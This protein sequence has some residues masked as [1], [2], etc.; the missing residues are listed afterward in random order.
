MQTWIEAIIEWVNCLGVHPSPVKDVRDLENKSIYLKIIGQ[1]AG[2]TSESPTQISEFLSK[3]YPEFLPQHSSNDII[4]KDVY[5]ASL[6]LLTSSQKISFHRPM[7]NLR[8]DTQILIKRFLEVLL[9]Y[10]K[11]ITQG[12]LTSTI[13]ELID[14]TPRTPPITPKDR[15]LRNFF[16]SPAAQSAHRHRILNEKTR[17]LRLLKAELETERYEKMDLQ[18]DIRIR[19][20]KIQTLQKKL[21]E[22]DLELKA[23]KADKCRPHTPQTGRKNKALEDMEHMLKKEI[24]HLESFNSHLQD[25]LDSAESDKEELMRKLTSKERLSQVLKEK[26]ETY[27]R[28]LE[29]LSIQLDQKSSELLQLRLQNEELRSHIKDM[30]RCS[31]DADQSF[32]VDSVSISR[33]PIPGLNTSEALSSIVD[34]QLQEAKEESSKLKAELT[35][36]HLR[37]DEAHQSCNELNRVNRELAI[38]TDELIIVKEKLQQTNEELLIME[39][40]IRTLEEEKM[41]F[42]REVENLQQVL[43][44]KEIILKETT[45]NCK[46]L[47]TKIEE[48][49]EIINETTE[50]IRI[51]NLSLTSHQEDMSRI[52]S[53]KNVLQNDFDNSKHKINELETFL[54]AE[55]SKSSNIVKQA[56]ENEQILEEKIIEIKLEKEKLEKNVE[57]MTVALDESAENLHDKQ[58]KI[59]SL[60]SL[61]D[62]LQNHQSIQEITL[63]NLQMKLCELNELRD[64][65]QS[66]VDEERRNCLRV[67]LEQESLQ[68]DLMAC[69]KEKMKLIDQSTGLKADLEEMTRRAEELDKQRKINEE[70]Y[71]KTSEKIQLLQTDNERLNSDIFSATAEMS[72]LKELQENLENQLTQE[73]ENSMKLITEKA[74]IE[75]ELSNKALMNCDLSERVGELDVQLSKTLQE[76]Q[77]LENVHGDL[78]GNYQRSVE[79][80]QRLEA[81]VF[82]T[83]DDIRRYSQQM[84]EMKS[85]I[86]RLEGQLE[87][88][89]C[90]VKS[91]LHD[92][93]ELESELSSSEG[94]KREVMEK[95]V[96][97]EVNLKNS[98]RKIE[99]IQ[100]ESEKLK[101]LVGIK[102]GEIECQLD[103]I[104]VLKGDLEA[105]MTGRSASEMRLKESERRY[106]EAVDRINSMASQIEQLNSELTRGVLEREALQDDRNRIAEEMSSR[107]SGL[108]KVQDALEIELKTSRNDNEA[109]SNDKS[110]LTQELSI[111]KEEKGR[112]KDDLKSNDLILREHREKIT[113]LEIY[114]GE[115][116]Q[117]R[118]E[119][120]EI[121]NS[122]TSDVKNLTSVLEQ[123]ILERDEVQNNLTGLKK[124]VTMLE[125]Q[126]RSEL[127]KNG[128]ISGEKSFLTSE[129]NILQEEN[130]HL[131]EK[132][133]VNGEKLTILN[134]EIEELKNY[135]EQLH[136]KYEKSTKKIISM[137]SEMNNFIIKLDETSI[138]RDLLQENLTILQKNIE[139][140]N[141]QLVTGREV[142]EILTTEKSDISVKLSS[143][144]KDKVDLVEKLACRESELMELQ[145]QNKNLEV[146]SKALQ[147]NLTEGIEKIN[148]LNSQ[149][150]NLNL[151]LQKMIPDLTNR[152]R[153]LSDQLEKEKDMIQVLIKEKSALTRELSK[154]KEENNNLSLNLDS[155]KSQL[156]NSNE[157]NEKL[158]RLSADLQEK[159]EESKDK[160]SSMTSEIGKLSFK[161][162]KTI[163]ECDLM[164]NHLK[165]Q[166]ETE[167]D[168][169][170]SEK[171]SLVAQLS[172]LKKENDDLVKNLNSKLE[173]L[174]NN[175]H[176]LE[177]KER[178]SF[179]KN[180]SLHS[181]IDN[182]TLQLQAAILE[183]NAC[184]LSLNDCRNEL[185]DSE[186][187]LEVERIRNQ[188]LSTEKCFLKTENEN[189]LGDVMSAKEKLLESKKKIE[190]LQCI[191]ETLQQSITESSGKITSQRSEIDTLT[192]HLTET[193]SAHNAARDNLAD[194]VK[195]L[196]MTETE[197]KKGKEEH[198]E[199]TATINRLE[200]LVRSLEGRLLNLKTTH[201]KLKINHKL[202]EEAFEVLKLKLEVSIR[203]KIESDLKLKE[204]ILS[205]Q[206]IRTSQDGVMEAQS[207]A[208]AQKN[209]ELE[210]LEQQ[211]LKCKQTLEEKINLHNVRNTELTKEL[212]EL[213]QSQECSSREMQRL[214]DYLK[215]ERN[216]LTCLKEELRQCKDEKS[217][218]LEI[219]K[220]LTSKLSTLNSIITSDGTIVLQ[221]DEIGDI[222]H[223]FEYPDLQELLETLKP[224]VNSMKSSAETILTLNVENKKL[225]GNLEEEKLKSAFLVKEKEKN[226]KLIDAISQL[227]SSQK[228]QQEAVLSIISRKQCFHGLVDEV[229][230]SRD[231]VEMTLSSLCSSWR[232]IS[233]EKQCLLS[234]SS[235]ACDE[236]KHLNAKRLEIEGMMGKI[237]ERHNASFQPLMRGFYRVLLWCQHQ[238]ANISLK[239][240]LQ[241]I[242]MNLSHES[243]KIEDPDDIE[244]DLSSSESILRSELQKNGEIRD[245][246]ALVVEKIQELEVSINSYEVNLKSGMV[247]R[248]PTPEEKLQTQLDRLSR[249]KKEMKEK[250]DAIRVRNTKMEKNID[251][252]RCENKKLKA[253]ILSASVSVASTTSDPSELDQLITLNENL[254]KENEELNRLK[255]ELEK[256][257]TNEE[258][259]VKLKQVHEEYGL[260]LE[261]I[262]Q[263]MKLAYNEQA[264]KMQMEQD[265]VIRDKTAE[266]KEKMEAVMRERMEAQCRKYT[267]DI[268]K[269]KAHVKELSS[270]YWDVGEKLLAEQQEKETAL[271][272]LK[273]LQRKHQM[274]IAEASHQL[275]ASQSQMRST[276]LDKCFDHDRSQLGMRSGFR[277]VQVIEEQTTTRRHSVKSIQAMG[278]AFK[279]EDEDEVFDNVYLT[280]LKEGQFRAI[281]PQTD[282]DRLSELRMRNSL[283][284]P[285]LKSSYAVETHLHPA[286]LTEEDMKGNELKSP[287]SR[288]LREK[289]VDRRTTATPKRLKDFFG[290]SLS[291]RHDE[292]APGT[293][294]GR[295]LSNIFR[296]PKTERS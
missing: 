247:K 295:R 27:E 95:L 117:K 74:R 174:Q 106:S 226:V 112:L 280:D 156:K 129:M 220:L 118:E 39:D 214:Q 43:A 162:E 71:L 152:M 4:P 196:E 194:V 252:L 61:V 91:L 240:D 270:Q 206:E 6:L 209:L 246:L 68:Q 281:E 103:E 115:L 153:D 89:R 291:R 255:E 173:A 202:K 273:E 119:C 179:K 294:K 195:R 269:Y 75:R 186:A 24:Q 236:V 215:I 101:T 76:L 251:D 54:A 250:L 128:V 169:I 139:Q 205:L 212:E 274:A 146:H 116:C 33:S 210:A 248:E 227:E 93:S 166:L 98:W 10:G 96:G 59:N 164:Q 241:G 72:R 275:I 254:R 48:Q 197:S 150:E 97:L 259:D 37:L 239:T 8:N 178:V 26:T 261:K 85:V 265:R 92:K 232:K 69:D 230:A 90:S 161:L 125:A 21:N 123:T 282:F 73:Q 234:E 200:E 231:E 1:L 175:C 192:L 121:I 55:M 51:L 203:E 63:N 238:L 290:T 23:F 189:L 257:P 20:E 296:K 110:F 113:E 292:N 38:K 283:C 87:A 25:Q 16:T 77:D 266:M 256:R 131:L 45:D 134:D 122:M 19:E 165:N 287:S 127:D 272:R 216:E 28:E 184:Q 208:L 201:D 53:E 211:Q 3:E 5:I 65:L 243:L 222:V 284:R 149:V 190:D 147:Q 219:I 120:T 213:H 2:E 30:Q 140:L 191:S 14:A 288:I 49:L 15:P 204:V 168:S 143:L 187:Q 36:M 278:N 94:E 17:E 198:E 47:N 224:L 249:E 171:L 244:I 67:S 132:V 218:I 109:L 66:Q 151:Q 245:S 148:S 11:S 144:E 35:S 114:S 135:S 102:E 88:E 277:T 185:K 235:S 84:S 225:I 170:K 104:N 221:G 137:T 100:G 58:Q 229:I 199:L 133:Y 57:K 32:E 78:T 228:R 126:W 181:E 177:E 276:S 86:C 242:E 193:T 289:N 262:K 223:S 46:S 207:K 268:N 279:A 263:R 29:A 62:S 7:C 64:E 267:V 253:E 130:K 145:G 82:K 233:L 142:N 154:M 183:S 182:L 167:K 42:E 285:H 163:S 40:K 52:N 159:C 180:T 286:A 124:Q 105:V 260:K 111:L 44:S 13:S 31:L 155:K 99:I 60:S 172:G 158:M 141:N 293:P 188:C 160:I 56:R 217:K 79:N 138:E 22:K 271:Q 81:D 107:I 237:S 34:I 176:T 157:N 264:T 83:S 50:N 41:H 18:E 12:I 80:V 108:Q 136:Q 9:P 70:K 258:F